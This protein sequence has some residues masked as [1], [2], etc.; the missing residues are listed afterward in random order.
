VADMHSYQ[1]NADEAI[2]LMERAMHL[3]IPPWYY[4]SLAFAYF[5]KRQYAKASETLNRISDPSNIAYLL[6]IACKA[7]LG[8]LTPHDE[9]LRQL[10]SKDPHWKPDHLNNFPF[11]TLEDQEHY[12]EALAE[13][14]VLVTD[15]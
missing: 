1:G 7:K 9:I 14:G 6:S 2:L 11:A 12:L 8:E 15:P 4:H 3:K 5:Q 13:A 10:H